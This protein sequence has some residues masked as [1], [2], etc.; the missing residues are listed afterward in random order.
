M[1]LTAA[2]LTGFTGIDSNTVAIDTV[3]N[4]LANLNTTSFKS[5]RTLF[6]TLLYNTVSEGEAPGDG[7]GGTLP[8]QIGF[9]STVA[10]LQ[11]DFRQG[12][13]ESTGF[14]SDLAIDGNG[15]FIVE[16]ANGDTVYTRDGSFRLDATQTL[17][18][19]NGA[20]LQAFRADDDGNIIVGGLDNIVV[21]LGSA[22]EAIATSIVQM[23]GRLDSNTGIASIGAV[24]TSQSLMV[25]GNVPAN[26]GTALTD[27][28]DT[29]GLPLF[30]G[31]DVLAIRGSRGGITTEEFT[32]V[33]D[34]TGSTVGDLAQSFEQVLGINRD[35]ATGNNTGVTIADGTE[36]PAGS[37]VIRS[38]VGE[39][40]AIE[41]DGSS[42]VNQNGLVTSP[43]SFNTTTEAIG[44]GVTTTFAVFDSLGN[45]V[46]VRLRAVVESKSSTGTVWRF[47]AESI[48]DSDLSP[49]LG[50]GTIT[51]DTNGRFV[52]ATGTDINIDLAGTGAASPMGFTIEFSQLTGLVGANGRSELIMDSQDGAPP[53][54]LTGYS[55]DSGGVITGAFSNQKT[56]VLGQVPIALFP[57]N[58]GLLA[59]A[60][61]TFAV[62]PNSGAASVELAETNGAGAIRSGALEQ[63]NVEVAREFIN[64][65]VAS[66]GISSASRVIRVADDL[67]QELLLIAR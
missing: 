24:V 16:A 19:A 45:Q 30:A 37:L 7:S 17:V 54:I 33:V 51:F 35:P 34:T 6:E 38:N 64:L 55:I 62:G 14:Q 63:S 12:S 5:Q 36:F 42:I 3:G 15:F 21:P 49:V 66:T 47:F 65:I 50:T 41:L 56:K 67:L 32:F 39:I 46:D 23:D 25:A 2:M 20:P 1:S 26:A 44:G 13:L 9:G 11:R 27:L 8:R 60:G 59:L 52:G 10:S 58:E 29:N 4:N 31:G 40:N 48:Q 43:F 57:N 22:S 61:N 53:G 18:A 28:V